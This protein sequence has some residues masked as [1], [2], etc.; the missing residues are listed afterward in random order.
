[1]SIL[2]Q[3]KVLYQYNWYQSD[4]L[5]Y[6]DI[7]WSAS[8]SVILNM[9]VRDCYASVAAV[10]WALFRD[11]FLYAP[12]QW[13]TTLHCN[14]VSH[15]LGAYKKLSLIIELLSLVQ[16]LY[17]L[18]CCCYLAVV[19]DIAARTI[20]SIAL[21]LWLLNCSCGCYEAMSVTIYVHAY[22]LHAYAF[23]T[24]SALV[25]LSNTVVLHQNL[26]M[27]TAE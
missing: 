20:V 25:A 8:L 26:R 11:N 19:Y 15:W 9:S 14:V 21:K 16:Q 2:I 18:Y 5:N 12:S 13:K 3:C 4:G 10:L 17:M 23:V 27:V 1:M 24:C 6:L 7:I 22:A